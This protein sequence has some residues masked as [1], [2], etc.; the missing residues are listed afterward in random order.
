MTFDIHCAELCGVWH[1]YM[2]DTGKVVPG[3]QFASWIQQREQQFAP[4][5]K[6]LPPFSTTYFPDPQ[7]RGG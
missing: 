2:F 1:G 3:A 4:A 7:R 6:L 5:T